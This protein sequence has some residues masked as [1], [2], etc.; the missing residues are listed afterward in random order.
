M[1]NQNFLKPKTS[2]PRSYLLSVYLSHIF[3]AWSSLFTGPKITFTKLLSSQFS[4]QPL[5]IKKCFNKNQYQL[6]HDKLLYHSDIN[7]YLLN[8]SKRTQCGS[9]L[10]HIQITRK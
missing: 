3:L 5:V 6:T 7:R 1:Q 10:G 2:V 4:H 8:F 9:N